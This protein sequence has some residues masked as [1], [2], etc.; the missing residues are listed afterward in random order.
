VGQNRGSNQVGGAHA[1]AKTRPAAPGSQCLRSLVLHPPGW[2]ALQGARALFEH[3]AWPERRRP[4]DSS[5][6]LVQFRQHKF[7]PNPH[8]KR[9]PPGLDALILRLKP[10]QRRLGRCRHR[11]L[12][13]SV[14]LAAP[15]RQQ[16]AA[17]AAGRGRRRRRA[18]LRRA[19][20]EAA[21]DVAVG[22]HLGE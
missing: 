17:A 6:R 11:K 22:R 8:P 13:E 5:P 4:P 15:R 10:L 2:D 7:N 20:D 18:G 14:P 16:R 3:S 19:R 12:D 9:L 21:D 1:V